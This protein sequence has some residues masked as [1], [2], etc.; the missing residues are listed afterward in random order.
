[1]I[2]TWTGF[3]L[4]FLILTGGYHSAHAEQ[5]PYSDKEVYSFLQEAFSAQISIGEDYF[6]KAE[7]E[8][9]LNPYF[10]KQYQQLFTAEHLV[11][12]Q[13]GYT[14]YGTDFAIYYIP[15]FSYNEDTKV[16]WSDNSSVITVYQFFPEDE[17]MPSL[18]ADHYEYVKLQLT[19][20]KFIVTDYGFEYE[21]PDF[22][23]SKPEAAIT[24]LSTFSKV[25]KGN[26]P[27]SMLA[28]LFTPESY[29]LSMPV[30]TR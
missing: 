7:V 21:K 10:T 14:T 25:W 1:M 8:E 11:K 2:K 12:D 6:T 5:Q 4:L 20:N 13:E 28:F 23:E 3:I 29:S 19:D 24:P 26:Y 16:L 30:V 15:F 9:R 22:L 17:S 18:Y 27:F